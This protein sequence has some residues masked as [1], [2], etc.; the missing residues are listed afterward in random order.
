ME[1]PDA[2]KAVALQ[3]NIPKANVEHLFGSAVSK[4]HH[5]S[6]DD[7][8][9]LTKLLDEV[10]QAFAKLRAGVKNRSKKTNAA[11]TGLHGLG[12]SGGGF[13]ATTRSRGGAAAPRRSKSG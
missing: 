13:G 11:K 4:D 1:A 10:D 3:K 7:A 12:Q 5:A 2:G 9:L 6:S 8:V